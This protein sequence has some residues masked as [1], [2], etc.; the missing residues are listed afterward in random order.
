MDHA[1][2][3]EYAAAAHFHTANSDMWPQ[4]KYDRSTVGLK[5]ASD[6]HCCPNAIQNG[7]VSTVPTQ[8]SLHYMFFILKIEEINMMLI[9][10]NYFV[11]LLLS[12]LFPEQLHHHPQLNFSQ[13]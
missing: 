5:C 8:Y 9:K 4:C 10:L 13:L 7:N 2:Y 1:I 6:V 12:N 11:V 3:Y